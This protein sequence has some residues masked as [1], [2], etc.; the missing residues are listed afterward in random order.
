MSDKPS[1]T[2]RPWN[3]ESGD[4][5][6]WGADGCVIAFTVGLRPIEQHEANAEFIVTA[7]NQ[8]DLLVRQRDELLAALRKIASLWPEPPNCADVEEVIGPNDGKQRAI[9]LKAALDISRA[10]LAEKPLPDKDER[11]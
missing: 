1:T 11:K 8:H 6:I 2:P 3:H 9:L 5:R 4:G 7:C 10:A